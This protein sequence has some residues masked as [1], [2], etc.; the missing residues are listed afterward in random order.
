[1]MRKKY[2]KTISKACL[3]VSTFMSGHKTY[4][5][6]Y[7]LVVPSQ[8]PNSAVDFARTNHFSIYELKFA[9]LAILV[10]FRE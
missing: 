3:F 4:C 2:I 8:R 10:E 9:A 6:C 1:M 5:L 7:V